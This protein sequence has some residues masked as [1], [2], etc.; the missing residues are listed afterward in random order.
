MKNIDDKLEEIFF[1]AN[2]K[3][4]EL[5]FRNLIATGS[6]SE[7]SVNPYHAESKKYKEK[8]LHKDLIQDFEVSKHTEDH[9]Q[10][11][12]E[13]KGYESRNKDGGVKNDAKK[14]RMNLV[15]TLAHIEV[16]RVMTYGAN[17]YAAFNWMEGFDWTVLIDAAERHIAQWK[18]GQDIDAESGH[19]HLGHAMCCLMML[20]DVTKLYP[21]RDD[22]SQQYKKYKHLVDDLTI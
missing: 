1:E 20:F 15:P 5:E 8:K 14:P 18:A 13:E 21:N 3:N 9:N 19:S 10:K 22:R 7:T 12:A 2:K 17:K 4:V 6:A 11:L 16:A